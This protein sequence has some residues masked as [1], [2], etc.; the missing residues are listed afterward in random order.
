MVP[1]S[2]AIDA[3]VDYLPLDSKDDAIFN[4]VIRKTGD[5]RLVTPFNGFVL[6]AKIVEDVGSKTGVI[7][8]CLPAGKEGIM[9]DVT[10]TT[11]PDSMRPAGSPCEYLLNVR[12]VC[13]IP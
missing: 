6:R 10:C 7:L 13:D 12:K 1:L 2:K 4:E 5:D 3:V 11:R 8:V 9:E